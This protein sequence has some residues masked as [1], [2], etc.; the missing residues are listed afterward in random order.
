MPDPVTIVSLAA[1]AVQLIDFGLKFCREVREI[2]YAGL[3][4]GNQDVQTMTHLWVETTQ[5]LEQGLTQAPTFGV[6]DIEEQ[7]IL[8]LARKC[9]SIGRDLDDRLSALQLK[10]DKGKLRSIRQA[11]KS[12]WT[13]RRIQEVTHQLTQYRTQLQCHLA[14]YFDGKREHAHAQ[15]HA[16][17]KQTGID[18]AN[19]A[20]QA[21][22]RDLDILKEVSRCESVLSTIN[23]RSCELLC[24]ADQGNQAISQLLGDIKR[25]LEKAPTG[26]DAPE[27][28]VL[29]HLYFERI[30]SR[31]HNV[32]EAYQSTFRWVFSRSS[33]T[34]RPSGA[35][36]SRWLDSGC[37][38]F[39][40]VGKAGS[41]KST[42][43]KYICNT[44]DTANA[45]T[46]WSRGH[47]LLTASFFA[48]HS[49]MDDQKT[50]EALFRSLLYQ[51]LSGRPDLI[52]QVLPLQYKLAEEYYLGSEQVSPTSYREALENLAQLTKELPSK[53][54]G[55]PRICIFIDGLD[56]FAGDQVVIAS[57]LQA[58]TEKYAG[59]KLVVSGRPLNRFDPLLESCPLIRVQDLTQQD[60]WRYAKHSLESDPGWNAVAA[61]DST[62]AS[63]LVDAICQKAN[64]VFLWVALVVKTLRD[65][66]HNGDS[67][68]ELYEVLDELPHE[69][70]DLYRHMFA[71]MDP[72][73][74]TQAAQYFRITQDFFASCPQ[75]PLSTLYFSCPAD[76]DLESVLQTPSL[77]SSRKWLYERCRRIEKRLKARNCGLLELHLAKN[78]DLPTEALI[79]SEVQYLHQSVAEFLHQEEPSRFI[80]KLAN[81]P[82]FDLD[83]HMC[84]ALLLQLKVNMGRASSQNFEPAKFLLKR[85][86][87][88]P[89]LQLITQPPL[90]TELAV[91][92]SKFG[93]GG[94]RHIRAGPWVWENDVSSRF[95]D[96]Y[97]ALRTGLVEYVRYKLACTKLGDSLH[98][99]VPPF[100]LLL[101]SRLK[102]DWGPSLQDVYAMTKL[103]LEHG[104]I[105]KQ[106]DIDFSWWDD[107]KDVQTWEDIETLLRQYRRCI[108]RSPLTDYHKLKYA[109]TIT[110]EDLTMLGELRLDEIDRGFQ[111]YHEPSFSWNSAL[112]K[113]EIV[114]ISAIILA[115]LAVSLASHSAFISSKD[116]LKGAL[117]QWLQV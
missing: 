84:R 117:L 70:S 78:T 3:S 83:L 44:E 41:G 39:Y 49:G 20:D 103:L 34:R 26:R 48:W 56:E 74:Q 73:Y 15:L 98:C 40:I 7:A 21:C 75:L 55:S 96:L 109:R 52:R 37:G 114:V 45:L 99:I 9:T 58:L 28:R 14:I 33:P 63:G 112:R 53:T 87:S 107:H 101:R 36:F 85:L 16:L 17:I 5:R 116:R 69:L 86:R 104:F 23:A 30:F 113:V 76:G 66:F 13:Q 62:G 81:S 29:G 19:K 88:V 106:R 100:W 77:A 93:D 31:L 46:K 64:G 80:S 18:A 91:S 24:A 11:I 102:G 105:P 68:N 2:S 72:R 67:I 1:N 89:R 54:F 60:I 82:T 94:M 92:F 4:T 61:Q 79:N 110:V 95:E 108:P 27:Q 90:V 42:L 22:Q 97:F 35:S 51:L 8:S 12:I 47:Y 43:V 25:K 71:R 6:Q 10:G 32:T 111:A 115:V 38:V 57:F 65:S 59:F 50:E